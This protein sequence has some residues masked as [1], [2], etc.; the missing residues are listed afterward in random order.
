[1]ATG[2]VEDQTGWGLVVEGPRRVVGL[3]S[4]PP[5]VS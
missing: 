5:P 2:R 3:V 1:M 4:P